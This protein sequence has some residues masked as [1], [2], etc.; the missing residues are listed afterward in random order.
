MQRLLQLMR[1]LFHWLPHTYMHILTCIKRVT[2]NGLSQSITVSSDLTVVFSVITAW[3][4]ADSSVRRAWE[5]SCAVS[6]LYLRRKKKFNISWQFSSLS[7]EFFFGKKRTSA[8]RFRSA[9]F[10][11]RPQGPAPARCW[12]GRH[13]PVAQPSLHI[14]PAMRSTHRSILYTLHA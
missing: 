14:A 9:R 4:L 5:S 6:N 3:I 10:Y 12:I 13:D 7:I 2:T 11:Y 1:Y 8:L